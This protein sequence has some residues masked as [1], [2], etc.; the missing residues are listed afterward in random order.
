MPVV[1][2]GTNQGLFDEKPLN[3]AGFELRARI[4][5]PIG[6]PTITDW[7]AALE[8][9]AS[10]EEASPYW[11]GDLLAYADTRIEW[12]E[13][14]SQAMSVTRLSEQWLHDLAYLCRRVGPDER[15][16]APSVEHARSVAPLSRTE[17]REWLQ[18][19]RAEG[20]TRGEMRVN[21]RT[22]KRRG[23]ISGQADLIGMF[24]VVYADPPWLYNDR[25]VITDADSYGR[26]ERYYPCMSIEELCKLPVKVTVLV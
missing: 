18:K 14:L 17:Q 9:A 25:R 13:K 7:E 16:L 15:E 10:C 5:V 24:R 20:W 8:F 2:A 12:R 4:A 6:R 23:V 22:A 21:L 3:V 19:A 1:S 26:A 11:V